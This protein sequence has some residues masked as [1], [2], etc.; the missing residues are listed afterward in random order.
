MYVVSNALVNAFLLRLQAFPNNDVCNFYRKFLV[1]TGWGI[2]L[3]LTYKVSQFDYE[4]SNFDPYE[5]LGVP[6]VSTLQIQKCT[7]C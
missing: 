3:F 2:L 7:K 5:I 6:L 4:Y 1:L